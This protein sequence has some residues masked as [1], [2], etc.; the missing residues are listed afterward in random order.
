ML[1]EVLCVGIVALLFGL[2]VTFAGYRFFLALL[3]FWGLLVG[4]GLGASVVTAIFGD[5]FLATTTGWIVGFVV[6]LVFA[7]LSYMF[8]IAGVAIVAGGLGYALGAGLMY[9]IFNDPVLLA[10]IVGV[11]GAVVVAALTLLL[12]LQKWLIM[13]I[14]ASSGATAIIASLLVFLGRIDLADFGTNPVQAVLDDSFFWSLAWLAIA[15]IGYVAQTVSTTYT[16]EPPDTG[17]AW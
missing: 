17:R 5:G 7:L 8:Y 12:N 16:L 14:T 11:V 9:A 6:G 10:F 1:F 3:P 13:A 4:F 15:V 2:V